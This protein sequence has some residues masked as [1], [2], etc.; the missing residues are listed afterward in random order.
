MQHD[1]YRPAFALRVAADVDAAGALS[2]MDVKLAGASIAEWGK[3]GRL[4]GRADTLA[5]STFSDTPYAIGNYRV[6]WVSTPGHVPVGV[7]RSVGQSHNGFFM[8]CAID[9]AAAAAGRDPLEFRLALLGG[10]PRLAAVLQAAARRAGWGRQLP[11]GEGLGLALVEDQ[12]SIVAE[13]AHVRVA[14]GKLRVLEVCCA[15]DCG[16]ALQPEFVRMQMEGGM[17]FGL[18]ALL[19]GAIHI[20][21]GAVRERNFHDYRMLSLADTP[22]MHVDIVDSGAALG[23]VGEPGVPP[24]APAVVNAIFAATGRRIRSLPLARHG[25]A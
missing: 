12:G 20:E 11:P 14:D 6:R 18:S 1:F 19:H 25:L 4:Q 9:E 15:I 5:V 21:N 3:P 22:A 10:H 24:L 16:R 8:E 7:W 23:G 17:V 13:A 2:A